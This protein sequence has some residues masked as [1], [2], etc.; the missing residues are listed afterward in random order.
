MIFLSLA[1]SLL[2]RLTAPV[3]VVQAWVFALFLSFTAKAT[4]SVSPAVA[5]EYLAFMDI[6]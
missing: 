2:E 6:V 5:M 4:I 1:L 3:R